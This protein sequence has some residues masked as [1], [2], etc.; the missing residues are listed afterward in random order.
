MKKQIFMDQQTPEA[1]DIKTPIV[2][3]HYLID[4]ELRPWTGK[5]TQIVSPIFVEE[6]GKRVKKLLGSVPDMGEKE[7]LEALEKAKE[8]YNLGRG[9]WPTMQV[10]DRIDCLLKFVEIMK[11]K[12]EEVVNLLMWEIGKTLGDSRK[13]FDRTIQYIYDTIEEYKEIDRSSARI[14][15]TEGVYAQI[16]R[17]PLGVV[18]CMGPYNY[19]L[20]ETFCLLIPALIMGNTAIFKPAKHGILLMSPLLEAFKEAF[21]KGVVNILYGRGRVVSTPIMKTGDVDVLALIGTSTAANA[22][23]TLHPKQNRLR[24][25]LGLEAKNPAIVMPDAD[26]DLAVSECVLGSLSF[27]GQRCTALKLLFVHEAVV[28]AFNQK[29]VEKVNQLK[30]GLPWEAG[31]ALTPLPEPGKVEY[32]RSLVA[33][34]EAKGAKV[35]NEDGGWEDETFYFPA[36]LYPVHKDMK[37]YQE[38]QFGPVVP[39][40]PF[41][42]IEEPINAVSESNYGQQVSLFSTNSEILAQLIDPLVNQVCRV[43]INSQCQRGPDV[44]P[45]VGRKDSAVS[46]LSVNDALRSFSIRTLVAAKDNRLNKEILN[47]LLDKQTSNFLNT[48]YIL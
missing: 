33:D 48:H 6:N 35:I 34:A 5:M 11:T 7:A 29:F 1:F 24:L 19:P 9:L 44:Y 42:D 3:S 36:I 45:F 37:I 39:I 12:R 13:E 30:G 27:N 40:I 25:V 4:G 15:L 46:T 26:L 38:E 32:L 18:L 8:A 23:Q 14:L 2:Q 10:K 31:V 41:K 47:E 16:R 43:N 20:N 22:L 21:P 17:G 28:D